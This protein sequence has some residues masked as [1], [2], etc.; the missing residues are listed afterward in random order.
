[1]CPRSKRS[2]AA[3]RSSPRRARR[4]RRSSATPRCT[5]RPATP[6]RSPRPCATLVDDTARADAAARGRADPGDA[7]HLGRAPSR[8]TSRSTGA[9]R[10][11][12][13]PR[14]GVHHRR[15][16]VRRAAPRRAPARVR[17][18]RRRVAIGAD[19]I[20]S[21]SPTATRSTTDSQRDRPEVV[22]HL[23]AFT[24]VGESWHRARPRPARQRRGHRCNV[25]DAARAAGVRACRRD[26]QR[27]GVRPRVRGRPA[28]REDDAAAADHA[29]RREQGR[30]VVP[31]AAGVARL[32][33]RDDP[34]AARSTTPARASR[35]TSSSRRWRSASSRPSATARDEIA[36]GY[37]DPVR[38]LNDVRDIVAR[39]PAARRP[40]ARRARSTT[41]APAPASRSR[42]SPSSCSHGRSVRCASSRIPRSSAR[43]RSRASS[44][45]PSKL[46]RGHRLEARV[47]AQPDARRRA[48][49]G[50]RGDAGR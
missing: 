13:R 3:R 6:T 9:C 42:R 30:G 11:A 25:L 23:A 2:R 26:R 5:S 10:H 20:R 48:R 18:R 27:R 32:R 29:V 39:V 43:S 19:P 14:E 8:R 40:T 31:R 36:V 1:M 44:A 35:R 38:D 37:L 22:Y 15:E 45:T 16:R 4:S 47:H 33:P 21:T 7:V 12:G 49:R 34:R 24:H 41:S 28:A 50:P 17:R 46:A